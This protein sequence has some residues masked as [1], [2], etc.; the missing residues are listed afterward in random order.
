ML[1]EITIKEVL[2]KLEEL[3]WTE[4]IDKRLKQRVIGDI[5]DNFPNIRPT[6]LDEILKIIII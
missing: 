6:T 5:Y 4:L 3:G 2:E 1:Q